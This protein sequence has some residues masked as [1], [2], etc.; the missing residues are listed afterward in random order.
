[1]QC[2][3]PVSRIPMVSVPVWA[4]SKCSDA[5]CDGKQVGLLTPDPA[6]TQ[7]AA[8]GPGG[9]CHHRDEEHARRA[10]G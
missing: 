8:D 10:P 9:L 5:V 3:A 1:M 2:S 6:A 4:I 7:Q